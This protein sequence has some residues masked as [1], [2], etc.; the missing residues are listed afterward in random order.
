MQLAI[1]FTVGSNAI[2]GTACM[3][4]APTGFSLVELLVVITIIGVLIALLLPA[5]Q[6]AREAAR[7]VSCLNNLHQIGIGLQNYHAACGCFPPGGIE[8][9]FRVS[10]GRQ[11]AW[12]AFLL[13]YIEQESLYGDDRF[14][15]A[16]LRGGECH[17]GGRR[18]SDLLVPEH[19]AQLRRWCKAAGR[20]ITAASTARTSLRIRPTDRGSPKT[21]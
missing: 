10:N 17:G 15:E 19:P 1:R 16:Q 18:D 4:S 9:A 3:D 14:L 2:C 20:R 8:P 13:P 7:R 5:V 21:A 11:F 12:S 6:A